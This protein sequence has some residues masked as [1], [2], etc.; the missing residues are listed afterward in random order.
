MPDGADVRVLPHGSS[1]CCVLW[2]PEVLTPGD[3]SR[4]E[5]A[6]S[7]TLNENFEDF[8][9]IPAEGNVFMNDQGMDQGPAAGQDAPSGGQDADESYG[10]G[11]GDA[12]E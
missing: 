3:V 5:E 6:P 2:S 4:E 8:E 1:P 10:D 9:A 7:S 12:E 11:E